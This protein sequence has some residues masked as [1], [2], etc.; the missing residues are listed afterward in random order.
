[1]IPLYRNSMRDAMEASGTA[2]I[3]KWK[4]SLDENIRCARFIEDRINTQYDGS[5]LSGDIARDSFEEFG[6]DRTNWVL[7]NTVQLKDYDGRFS[8]QSKAWAQSFFIP[9]PFESRERD[10]NVDYLIDKVNPGLVDMVIRDA[11]KHYAALNLYDHRHRVEGDIHQ[12]DFTGKLLILRD[13]VLNEASRTPENQLFLASGGFGCSPNARGRA[14]FGEFLIDGEKARFER[15]DFVGI[16]DDRYLA[17]WA[18][19]KLAELQPEQSPE[20]APD[21]TSGPAMKGM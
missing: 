16:V 10:R 4:E 20:E 15:Q 8:R 21:E 9:R 2:E 19:E 18:K 3:Q 12:Q 1:M 13:T 6:M 14:V 11:R 5:R 7:A 17:D